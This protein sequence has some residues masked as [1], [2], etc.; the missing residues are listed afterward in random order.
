M[1]DAGRKAKE[2]ALTQSR[3][4][5]LWSHIRLSKPKITPATDFA[6]GDSFTIIVEVFLGE[7]APEEVQVQIYHGKMRGTGQMEG[8]RAEIMELQHT[9]AAGTH[10]YGCQVTCS[11]S[12][13]FGY[14]ARVIPSGDTVLMNTPG[15]ITWVATDS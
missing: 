8:S 3:L 2:L 6:V 1:E 12:G 13:R 14:T 7:L 15:L 5:A 11:N 10:V 4:N 9:I